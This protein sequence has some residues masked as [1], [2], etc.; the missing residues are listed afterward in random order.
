MLKLTHSKNKGARIGEVL[1]Y[2]RR[3]KRISQLELALA[4]D[5]SSKHLSF[6][7][8]GKAQPSRALILRLAD[9][10]RLPFRQRNALLN[11]AG[12]SAEFNEEPFDVMEKGIIY[13]AL[14]RI[15][16]KHE[17]YPAL[18]VNTAYEILLINQGFQQI[19]TLYVGEEVLRKY[20]NIYHLMFVQDGLR[21]YFKD[22]PEISAF[23]L[24]RLLSEAIS[25]QN[26]GLLTLYEEISGLE[27]KVETTELHMESNIP[28]MSFTLQKGNQQATFFSTITTFGTPLD[29]TT[30]ELRIES[31][32]PA[33]E[34]TQQLCHHLGLK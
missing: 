12:Y 14:Y 33:D 30:Q 34:A 17:P 9:S 24:A 10:L 23:L 15:L 1:R 16:S 21:S 31:L 22:W 28:V 32:F 25:T 26:K 11:V 6:V 3:L 8:T 18:V 29:V 5:V 2:W 20:S 19:V 4:V 7:E 27:N 13:E